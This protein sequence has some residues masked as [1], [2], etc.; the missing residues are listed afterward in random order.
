MPWTRT[1]DFP[2][3]FANEVRFA[4]GYPMVQIDN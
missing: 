1:D 2:E 4:V 3:W